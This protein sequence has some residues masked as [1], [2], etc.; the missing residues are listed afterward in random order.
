[1]LLLGYFCPYFSLAQGHAIISDGTFVLFLIDQSSDSRLPITS[2]HAHNS[3][4]V[5]LNQTNLSESLLAGAAA[6]QL[7]TNIE[8]SI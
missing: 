3:A 5:I 2:I 8:D 4:G 1:M 7:G 6:G